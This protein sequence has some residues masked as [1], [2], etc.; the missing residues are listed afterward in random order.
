VDGKVGLDE[1][2]SDHEAFDDNVNPKD[3]KFNR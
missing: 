1:V 3:D 2:S